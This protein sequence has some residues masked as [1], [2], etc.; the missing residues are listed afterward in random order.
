MAQ[1][2]QKFAGTIGKRQSEQ[3]LKLLSQQR[4]SGQIRSV[5]EF[6]QKLQGLMFD[7]TSTVLT[8]SLKHW[9]AEQGED[10]DS[11]T[12]NFMLDRVEDDLSA[13][14]EE[15]NNIDEVQ[16]SHEA[17]VRDVI[18]KNLRAGVNELDSKITLFEFLNKDTRG[19]DSAIFSTFRES[20]DERT[21]RQGTQATLLFRDPREL[22]EL[23]PTSQDADVELIGERLVLATDL[24]PFYTV[25]DVRQIFDSE[26][27][28][29]E[30]IVEPAGTN[31]RNIVDDTQGTYWIQSLLFSEKKEFVKVKVELNLGTVREI[32]II[33]I[34]PAAQFGIVVEDISYV[35][36]NNTVV[37]LGIPER[38]ID[39]PASI[40]FRKIATDRII[41]TFRND[42]SCKTN[43]QFNEDVQ[44]L[45]G[46]ALDQPPLKV[47]PK[48]DSLSKELDE[49]IASPKIKA[50]LGLK[51]R[52]RQE[53]QGYDFTTGID[54]VRVG[55]TEHQ[56]RSIYISSPLEVC[57]VGELGLRTLESRPYLEGLGQD[58]KF[59]STT[60]D[61]TNDTS[62]TDD[63]TLLVGETSNTY[64]I[65]SIEYWVVKQD[66]DSEGQLLQTTTFPVLPLEVGRVEHER[67]VL[68]GKSATTLS[69]PDLGEAMFFTNRTDGNIK[70]YRNGVLI[71]DNTGVP[72]ASDGWQ[73]VSTVAD[74]TPGN[75]TP[76]KFK[77]QILD[78]LPGDIFTIS[79]N[80]VTSSTQAL[81]KNLSEFTQ[82][83]GLNTVDLVGDLSARMC[84][85]QIV[86]LNRIGEDDA[87]QDSN[88]FLVIILR[89]NAAEATLTP[90]VEE[91]TLMGACKDLTK[92][93]EV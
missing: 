41:I 4:N 3:I 2:L 54:N 50:V 79:Y 86:I 23:I 44:P 75:G 42:N 89:Q 87:N 82:V 52:T 34:E 27:P 36:G 67:L 56:N 12:Y 17:I 62:L 70:V 73:D 11:E 66:V 25:A 43:F 88:V 71:T 81:P 72:L 21:Q 92:F 85:G 63:S 31:L 55:L 59:T 76:M 7:L 45:F 14:F 20:K 57:G 77:V 29:S 33:E 93:E 78:R 65:G 9:M 26:S 32:N 61:I 51:Q 24:S 19:F 68:T 18:L 91:Y 60:Y 8:P 47:E 80:P 48:P 64:F 90:A 22:G 38:F 49:A 69:E 40:R 37:N 30:L 5:Q 6:T 15:A 74:R 13:G 53:F 84:A 16:R 10:I 35:D 58:V 83:G 28:Q 1:Y 46:Q 39:A